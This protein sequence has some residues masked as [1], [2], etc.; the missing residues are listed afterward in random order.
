MTLVRLEARCSCSADFLLTRFRKACLVL[1]IRSICRGLHLAWKVQR[2]LQWQPEHAGSVL[3]SW[4]YVRGCSDL[5]QQASHHL[6]SIVA[7]QGLCS[8][9]SFSTWLSRTHQV[10][11]ARNPQ[12]SHRHYNGTAQYYHVTKWPASTCLHP[13]DFMLANEE[14][15]QLPIQIH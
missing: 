12:D 13:R 10:L 14:Q 15:C 4:G 6:V 3:V 11:Q 9:V 2:T 7:L 5:Q 1:N 8:H